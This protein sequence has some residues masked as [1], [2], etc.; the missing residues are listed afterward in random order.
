MGAI[1][2]IHPQ[3]LTPVTDEYGR[4]KIMTEP[5]GTTD[6]ERCPLCGEPVAD[7]P[8]PRHRLVLKDESDVEPS[9]RH[10]RR[11]CPTCWDELCETIASQM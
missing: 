6:E 2:D 1:H 5:T 9:Q 3:Y 11:V 10:E 4:S 8:Y 7:S